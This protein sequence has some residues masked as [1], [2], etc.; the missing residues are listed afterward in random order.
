MRRFIPHCLIGAT[1]ALSVLLAGM[2]T[3][4]ALASATVS[5]R[6]LGASVV[7]WTGDLNTPPGQASMRELKADHANTLSIVLPLCQSMLTSDDVE[8]CG[9]MPSDTDLLAAIRYARSIGL[10]VMLN[11][12]VD[13]YNPNDW[14]ANINPANRTAWFQAYGGWLVH[15]ATLGQ[16]AGAT[17]ICLGTEMYHL[18]DPQVNRANTADWI[19]YIIRPVRHVF[20]GWLTYS[21]QWGS[22]YDADELHVGFW[23]YLDKIG[24]SA[25]FSLPGNGSAK[26]LAADWAKTNARYIAPLRKFGKPILFTEV[27]YRNITGDHLSPWASASGGAANPQE[28]VRDYNA[29]LGYWSRLSWWNGVVLWDWYASGQIGPSN[30]DFTPQGKPAEATMSWWFARVS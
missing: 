3:A 10:G 16:Q 9:N 18:T 24:L 29:L 2:Q 28:Q 6:V 17:G 25:Y 5:P 1:V 7:P 15:Y 30:L 11:V 4:L 12:H 8:P 23:P 27:G 21:A 26:S 13:T 22:G 19:G 20:S 14:R